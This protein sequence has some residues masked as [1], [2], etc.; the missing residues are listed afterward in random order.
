[1][2]PSGI[3]LA[4]IRL[5]AQCPNQMRHNYFVCSLCNGII[6]HSK[7]IKAVAIRYEELGSTLHGYT[8]HQ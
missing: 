5:E 2:T 4:A 7:Q 1:M 6:F 3:E 8:V